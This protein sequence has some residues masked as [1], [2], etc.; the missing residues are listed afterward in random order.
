MM[1][2]DATVNRVTRSDYVL[3]A[4]ERISPYLALKSM[5]DW[6]AYQYFEDQYK[7]TLKQGKLADLVILDKNPLIVPSR[8]IKK[9]KVLATYK[10]GKLIYQ[11]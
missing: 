3:G 6:A 2:L 8:E 11:Q 7:G 4:D 10:E 1:M 9:I 5:T